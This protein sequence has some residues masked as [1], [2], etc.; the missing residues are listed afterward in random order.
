MEQ[1]KRRG[2]PSLIRTTGD[3]N[4]DVAESR[5]RAGCDQSDI[6]AAV[7]LGQLI[8]VSAFSASVSKQQLSPI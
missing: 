4:G 5:C 3:L 1:G 2:Q 8:H 6:N 7:Y